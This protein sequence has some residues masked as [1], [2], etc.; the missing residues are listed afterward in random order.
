MR[1]GQLV[2]DELAGSAR[3]AAAGG[4]PIGADDVGVARPAARGDRL[5][6]GAQLLG[7]HAPH[8][9]RRPAKFAPYVRRDA[10]P[11]RSSRPSIVAGS[12][13]PL[14]S[15]DTSTASISPVT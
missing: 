12:P 2:A 11:M 4:A 8:E 10:T 9:G 5:E 6:H 3:R 15:Y 13:R 1:V 7:V 14:P